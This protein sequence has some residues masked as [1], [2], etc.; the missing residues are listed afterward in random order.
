MFCCLESTVSNVPIE[1]RF[2]KTVLPAASS[3]EL[4]CTKLMPDPF[5]VCMHSNMW[6]NDGNVA[7]SDSN[8]DRLAGPVITHVLHCIVEC[9]NGSRTQ[10]ALQTGYYECRRAASVFW[11][12]P[13]LSHTRCHQGAVT[14]CISRHCR[15]NLSQHYK[16]CMMFLFHCFFATCKARECAH[17]ALVMTMHLCTTINLPCKASSTARSP[18]PLHTLQ[19]IIILSSIM[20]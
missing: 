7:R 9:Y 8:V 13:T 5:C 4:N 16:R 12:S 20:H 6:T 3:S 14:T 19:D 15:P 2:Q 1:L 10:Y 18:K 11:G 17:D